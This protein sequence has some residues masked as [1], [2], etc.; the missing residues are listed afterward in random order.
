MSVL[1]TY[2]VHTQILENY[3][4]SSD[5]PAEGRWKFKGGTTYIVES[6][7]IRNAVA[8]VCRF[9]CDPESGYWL[10]FPKT[11]E[12][13]EDWATHLNSLDDEYMEFLLET[14]VHLKVDSHGIPLVEGE[15]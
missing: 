8:L 1:E 9:V 15:E 5:N 2:A 14:A 3:N 4:Y 10:E 11:W 12:T 7:N 6:D 13:Y